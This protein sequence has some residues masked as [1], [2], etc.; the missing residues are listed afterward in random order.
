MSEIVKKIG[1]LQLKKEQV[2]VIIDVTKNRK[3]RGIFM[4][5]R[6]DF[7]TNSSSSSFLA[8]TIQLTDDREVSYKSTV[9]VESGYFSE[10]IVKRMS[11]IKN[12]SNLVD[13]L[14]DFWD[15]CYSYT[16]EGE[17]SEITSFDDILSIDVSEE[18]KGYG[19][20]YEG[21]E[22]YDEDE[23]EYYEDDGSYTR[24][25]VYDFKT[26]KCT[27]D[28][29]NVVND[30]KRFPAKYWK[31][32]WG[33]D[34]KIDFKNEWANEWPNE[35][36]VVNYSNSVIEKL[37]EE[38]HCVFENEDY[39]LCKIDNPKPFTYY[40]AGDLEH[41]TKTILSYIITFT[42]ADDGFAEALF[43]QE[44]VIRT[45]FTEL[46]GYF[47]TGFKHEYSSEKGSKGADFEMVDGKLEY[48][49]RVCYGGW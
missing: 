17:L 23:D 38:Y 10:P 43:E 7:V 15:N 32:Y 31:N 1:K 20:E 48:A 47:V 25:A 6:T 41:L 9:D 27:G 22:Y 21:Y 8:L 49:Y 14:I 3:E 46:D 42:K 40:G 11:N 16:G 13:F 29:S 24:E 19:S 35:D 45:N 26:K 33:D 28:Y 2:F 39:E 5:F 36:L 37:A 44:K 12:M 18:V 34:Y 4:K 30:K